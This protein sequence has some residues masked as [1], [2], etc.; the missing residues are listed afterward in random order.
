MQKRTGMRP[1]RARS[2]DRLRDYMG[3]AG[4]RIA[5]YAV[6]QYTASRP[7]GPDQSDRGSQESEDLRFFAAYYTR[8]DAPALLRG[9]VH[10]ERTRLIPGMRIEVGRRMGS[11]SL[12]GADRRPDLIKHSWENTFDQVRS[13]SRSTRLSD[14]KD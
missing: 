1:H 12:M 2:T 14:Y 10:G 11:R 4:G 9:G 13:G 6:A 5:A 7:V 8:R 3:S